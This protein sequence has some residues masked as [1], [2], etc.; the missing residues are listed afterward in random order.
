MYD[1]D[2]P[3]QP[4]PRWC[5]SD[6][7][8]GHG[9]IIRYAGRPTDH[10]TRM[11]ESWIDL[12]DPRDTVL[13]LGDVCLCPRERME[14]I[15]ELLPGRKL[16]IK[17]NHDQ[18]GRAW[19]TSIGFRV[20]APQAV[21]IDGWTVHLTHAPDPALVRH[22]RHLNVH[23]HIHEKVMGDRRM[24]NLAVEQTGY[25]PVELAEVVRE[26]I[27]ELT[28]PR[29]R[30]PGGRAPARHVEGDAPGADPGDCRGR[31]ADKDR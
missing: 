30:G 26:R 2:D 11:I 5:I 18:R 1:P 4:L 27:E 13:H 15:A 10:E 19:F 17:G 31:P 28:A 14:E 12:V 29:V 23:G 16:L 21:S 25:R 3:L 6:T 24:I 22:P 9:N 7:H 8:F 20:I